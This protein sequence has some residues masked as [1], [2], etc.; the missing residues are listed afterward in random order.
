MHALIQ[1]LAAHR[2]QTLETHEITLEELFLV[3]LRGAGRGRGACLT[4]P[5]SARR[6]ATCAGRS[7]GW[8]LGLAG[9][10]AMLVL[11]YPRHRRAVRGRRDGEHRVRGDPGPLGP[12]PVLPGRVLH[13]VAGADD[14]LRDHRRRPRCWPARRVRAPSN[15]CSRS[16]SPGGRC[17]SASSRAWRSPSS[18]SS[19]SPGSASCSRPRS[20]ISRARWPRVS[21]WSRPSRCCRSH[22]SRW[23]RRSSPPRS[24]RREAGPRR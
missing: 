5:S 2:V 17:S 6:C 1:A 7:W 24:R 9:L 20:S 11:L 14:R 8:G 12:A 18:G 21:W 10:A 19:R 3:V 13:V 23:Q 16:H 4:A 22:G 15:C